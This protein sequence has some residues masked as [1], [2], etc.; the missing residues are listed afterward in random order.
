MWAGLSDP[1]HPD[2]TL[3]SAGKVKEKE[4]KVG[5]LLA[6]LSSPCWSHVGLDSSVGHLLL[7]MVKC[8]VGKLADHQVKGDYSRLNHLTMGNWELTQFV[9]FSSS[10]DKFAY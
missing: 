5:L 1:A 8:T 2:W 10:T 9:Y 6:R 3:V 7:A 4:A